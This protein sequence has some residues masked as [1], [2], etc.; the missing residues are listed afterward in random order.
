MKRIF[1]KRTIRAA[2]SPPLPADEVIRSSVC[3]GER[4]GEGSRLPRS[5]AK[6][7]PSPQPSPRKKSFVFSTP[8]SG[9]RGT[10]SFALLL[11]LLFSTSLH[12]GWVSQ[13]TTE[14][15]TLGDWNADGTPDL[16]VLDRS[17]GVLRVALQQGADLI[18]QEPIA[19]GVEGATSI[20]FGQF[21]LLGQPKAAL[22]V[23]SPALNR[24][25]L[26]FPQVAEAQAAYLPGIGPN[27]LVSIAGGPAGGG[28]LIAASTLNESPAPWH[29]AQF[30]QTS[31]QPVDALLERGNEV[32]P[33]LYAFL[34]RGTI[35]DS[36]RLHP[37]G[38]VLQA[39][40]WK[41]LAGVPA[42]ADWATGQF[43]ASVNHREYLFWQSGQAVLR[44]HRFDQSAAPPDFGPAA[45]FT[46]PQGIESVAVLTGSTPPRLLVIFNGGTSAGVYDFDG[47]NA[48]TLAH[49]LTPEAGETFRSALAV[50][51]GDFHMLSGTSG[52]ASSTTA[53]RWRKQGDGSYL[54]EAA[55]TLPAI[56]SGVR[57][58]NLLLYSG[59]PFVDE[60]ARLVSTL[61]SRDWTAAAS[62]LPGVIQTTAEIFQSSTLGLGQAAS[63][64]LGT[65]TAG[66]S[67]ALPN[68]YAEDVSV[69]LYMPP[70]GV[71]GPEL[72]LVPPPGTY[73]G[74][75]NVVIDTAGLT[76]AMQVRYRT[77]ATLPWQTYDAAARTPIPVTGTL[78]L[79]AYA[80]SSGVA[81][82]PVVGGL[83]KLGTGSSPALP[84]TLAATSVTATGAVL[85]GTVNPGGSATTARFDHAR[86]GGT[87]TSTAE[88]SVGA[89]ATAQPVS[90]TLTGLLPH[91]TYHFRVTATSSEGVNYGQKLS[92]TTLNR[93]PVFAD[94]TLNGSEDSVLNAQ[95]TAS[96]P[97]SDTLTFTKLTDPTH[98]SLSLSSSGLVTYTPN[99]NFTGSD[100][101]TAKVADAFG[102]EDNA[103]I[104]LQIANV[105]DTPV[106]LA[107]TVNGFR[108][109]PVTITL[110]AN[111]EEGGPFTTWE[112][113]T[114]PAHGTLTGTAPYVEYTPATN[115][116]G[117]DS[118]T[119]R[120]KDEGPAFSNSAVITIQISP[121]APPGNV[122]TWVGS[123]TDLWSDNTS[124]DPAMVP[125]S[126][127]SI[128]VNANDVANLNMDA[129]V[130][131][132]NL[133][134]GIRG[135]AGR[136][137]QMADLDMWGQ[138][139]VQNYTLQDGIFTVG[140]ARVREGLV[141]NGAVLNC[142]S[143]GGMYIYNPV[144]IIDDVGYFLTLENGSTLNITGNMSM[145]S[146][147]SP[148][149][150]ATGIYGGSGMNVFNNSGTFSH[151]RNATY[152]SNLTVSVDWNN[153]GEI[154][155]ESGI[156]NVQGHTLRQTAGRLFVKDDC[157]LT[158]DQ[159]ILLDGGKLVGGGEVEAPALNVTAA[160][161]APGDETRRFYYDHIRELKVKNLN[162]SSDSKL[163]IELGGTTWHDKL[164]VW[165]ESGTFARN[166]RLEIYF[167][168]GFHQ[169]VQSSHTFTILTAKSDF[170]GASCPTTGQ[171]SNVVGGRVDTADGFGSFAVNAAGTSSVVLSDFQ[172][173]PFFV[174]GADY[175]TGTNG[176]I[177]NPSTASVN[178]GTRRV[179]H[180]SPSATFLIVNYGRAALTGI[181]ATVTGTHASDFVITSAPGASSLN[182]GQSTS[183]VITFTPSAQGDRTATLTMTSN[184]PQTPSVVVELHGRGNVPPVLHLPASPMIVPAL[185]FFGAYTSFTA[186]A[187]DAEDDPP[188]YV[189]TTP[190]SY[191]FFPI[192]DTVVNAQATDTTGDTTTGSFIIRVV[193][194]PPE[195]TTQP[196][197]SITHTAATLRG[198]VTP[199]G[200]HTYAHYEY[201][202]T[203]A[204]GSSTAGQY[205]GSDFTPIAI[206]FDLAGLVPNTPYYAQLVATSASGTTRS[207]MITFTTDPLAAPPV[208]V[209]DHLEGVQD[210]LLYISDSDLTVNDLSGSSGLSFQ[211]VAASNGQNCYV[212]YSGG[213]IYCTPD[214]GFTGI[215]SFTYT[216]ENTRGGIASGTAFVE[217]KP[218]PIQP[219]IAGSASLLLPANSITPWMGFT[220]GPPEHAAVINV[221][222]ETDNASLLPVS[223][224]DLTGTGEQR[225]V[226][227]RP[228]CGQT[229]T[230]TVTLTATS[231]DGLEATTTYR[232]AVVDGSS[233]QKASLHMMGQAPAA[234]NGGEG[235][236]GFGGS[237]GVAADVSA[238]GAVTVG[239][240]YGR[241][242]GPW[243]FT[244]QDGTAF[245][246]EDANLFS[247][248][249]KAISGDGSTL[250]GTASGMEGATSFRWTEALGYQEIPGGAEL[251]D[252]SAD[253]TAAAGYKIEF[254]PTFEIIVSAVRW[255]QSGG[256][257]TLPIPAGVIQARATDISAD[258][259]TITG[260]GFDATYTTH[261]IVWPATGAPIVL[262]AFAGSG[263]TTAY[264]VSADGSVVVGYSEG[265]TANPGVNTAVRWQR[266]PGGSY[267]LHALP[268]ALSTEPTVAYA[269]SAD[270]SKIVGSRMGG[271]V[272]L[273]TAADG[274]QNL[275]TLL[276]NA[277]LDISGQWDSL[278]EPAAISADG[279]VIV[280]T[281]YRVGSFGGAP[282]R[283]ELPQ[284]PAAPLISTIADQSTP[285]STATAAIPFTISDADTNPDCLTVTAVASNPSL[286]PQANIT[287]GGSGFS[288]TITLTPASGQ[289]GSALVVI[290]V[291]DGFHSADSQ[292]VLNVGAPYLD[293][294]QLYFGTSAN[295]GD[296]A[297]LADP[298]HDGHSNLEEFAFGTHPLSGA[299][300]PLL[301][302]GNTLLAPGAP[303]IVRTGSLGNTQPLA[304]FCRRKN[305]QALGL[306]YT[307]LFSAD[308]TH[309]AASTSVPTVLA[310][311]DELEVV[312]L[313]F[314]ATLEIDGQTVVPRFF[315]V[316]ITLAP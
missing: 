140:S 159:P 72:R 195:V 60:N 247:L 289:E 37:F 109:T 158:S 189:L 210:T 32:A 214:Y 240:A 55:A 288:R 172:P 295:N 248:A 45:D 173:Y 154:R 89:G 131:N 160:T 312:A 19:T 161:I 146:L 157:T 203:P 64:N 192:G 47:V 309:K 231:L 42:G 29:L 123:P 102:G 222:A 90:A 176:I 225:Q 273:W 180:A 315:Q 105:N 59:E 211:V 126:Q 52:S 144:S 171:F 41:T 40:P 254:T 256:L 193:F 63:V 84:F 92:F 221:T 3:C 85:N 271:V 67:H 190:D 285:V 217:F 224:I 166:G 304:V 48:P 187:T 252:I 78:K 128:R 241:D 142:G 296:A 257:T 81:V 133:Y 8:N 258:G 62:G 87:S 14:L 2:A 311:N 179:N 245:L 38:G 114:P 283:I 280:G 148:E 287:L 218:L 127:N 129:V 49:T 275:Q 175:A 244:I 5:G 24:V 302:S 200:Q 293:W 208:T 291:S 152:V 198:T 15:S 39:T 124:W 168:D 155:Q 205:L 276:L 58:A 143:L 82:S 262:P 246:G 34:A 204:L 43:S 165:N 174:W 69:S 7:H 259:S 68:Q 249:A 260:W 46:L 303:M 266:G 281:G 297:D 313:P 220:V 51:A 234:T 316:Q 118:L 57:R 294:K 184:D 206:A 207:P 277:G 28:G 263:Y 298:E 270:G 236:G 149:G 216:V 115:Y 188:P 65:S 35:S 21:D 169:T 212:S 242:G 86:D 251:Q 136:K 61:T 119:F 153:S 6:A 130:S 141:L 274:M 278:G 308:I 113:L 282:W 125:T 310:A 135:Q 73:A 11:A 10:I 16:L 145:R 33:A 265:G 108:N 237:S 66:P 110:R 100:T 238:D 27:A 167:D 163:A 185:S 132:A 138:G 202:I 77:D 227:L 286:L 209:V 219:L 56:P 122:R 229:G 96:D 23:T 13:S 164:N 233:P 314:P 243:T 75:L 116:S 134:G 120:V 183:F 292:F 181:S 117:S 107:Q 74:K 106:A 235:G 290:T 99:P 1:N 93:P 30:G 25:Q 88:Q 97:D 250:I 53:R 306:T 226:R 137:L 186:T 201:G 18:W 111:D 284:A 223:R 267:T 230:V 83:Y 215:A 253:G 150:R 170:N 151:T 139:N 156:L 307:V 147:G 50:G 112:I 9:E 94:A 80:V 268:T 279:K 191:A 71:S 162:L 239:T 305:H 199:R 228:V 104:T 26:I 194:P 79:E 121:N 101:F 299:M 264:D 95:L 196:P 91:T 301:F 98:G 272:F 36:L 44:V 54:P 76:P 178:W 177:V 269:V 4:S 12:A 70:Q 17:T 20:A 22:A 255:S 197:V 213:T 300:G 182:P 232:L 261:A 31:S 103:T